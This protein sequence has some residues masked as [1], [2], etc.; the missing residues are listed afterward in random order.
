MNLDQ[1]T[2]TALSDNEALGTITTIIDSGHLIPDLDVQLGALLLIDKPIGW[3]SFDVVNKIRFALRYQF[4]LKKLKVGHAGTLDPLATGLLLVCVGKY[5]KLIDQ[6]A[7][8]DKGYLGEAKFGAVTESYDAESAETELFPIHHLSLDMI[9]EAAKTFEGAIDQIPP[10]YSAIKINGQTA[11]SLARKGKEVTMKARQISIHNL[12][13]KSWN[14]P[15]L[16]FFVYCSKGTYI[17][18]LAHDLG[19][20]VGSGAY[21]TALRRTSI[22]PYD[23]TNALT[24]E[25]LLSYIRTFEKSDQKS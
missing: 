13:I 21:L 19:Q 1:K 22:G 4:G 20:A 10:Q 24:I 17:R 3:T 6:L 2:K 5:T 7:G 8:M 23:V 16:E 11:Y 25:E 9:T 18:S 15:K 12:E 14:A